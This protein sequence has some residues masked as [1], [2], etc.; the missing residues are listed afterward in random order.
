MDFIQ[1]LTF[2]ATVKLL[3]FSC[4]YYLLMKRFFLNIAFIARFAIF[5][6]L[7]KLTSRLS[8][9]NWIKEQLCTVSCSK[10]E[11]CTSRSSA[12]NYSC[13][14]LAVENSVP[15]SS[16][17]VLRLGSAC[18]ALNRFAGVWSVGIHASSIFPWW[19]TSWRDILDP[20]LSFDSLVFIIE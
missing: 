18:P 4:G 17:Q 10:I 6:I 8:T 9:S 1:A 15:N 13:L 16:M 7:M 3:S 12:P 20:L 2:F 14:W 5:Y 11:H 19:D